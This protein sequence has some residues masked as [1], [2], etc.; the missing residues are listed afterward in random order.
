MRAGTMAMPTD[1]A[2]RFYIGY[3]RSTPAKLRFARRGI[4]AGPAGTDMA[5][6][7]IE[8]LRKLLAARRGILMPG[9]A[10]ALSARI[11]A[12][13]GFETIYL[14]GA[15]LTNMHLGLP[16]YAFM[17]LT[18]LIE[19]TMAIRGVIDLPLIVDADTGFGNALN[20]GRAVAMLERA[21]AS[22]I[23]LEDQVMPKRCG[24]FDGQEVIPVAEMVGKVKAA[25]DARRDG[26]LIV[27]R[28][29]ARGIEGFDAAID[30]AQRYIEAGA[31]ITF[32][33]APRSVAELRQ[34]PQRLAVPQ[35]LNMVIGGKTPITNRVAA[36]EMGFHLVL[37]ANVAL[38]GAIKGMQAALTVLL[39][40]GAVDEAL[41]LTATFIERQRL[42][43]KSHF[44]MLSKRYAA[45]TE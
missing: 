25:V 12:D 24:H 3:E 33:E 4:R 9:A 20:V 7:H 41:G 39:D 26:V 19:H 18:Q 1:A 42:V 15:G 30:R 36:E 11:I 28:T 27:A 16:D 40:R 17:D 43:D 2:T 35:I 32:V 10:N 31:D 22:A 8:T 37:Y 14:T 5:Q 38:Q 13:L 6:D 23:Q 29:D 21:G 45:Q 44:D 34:I